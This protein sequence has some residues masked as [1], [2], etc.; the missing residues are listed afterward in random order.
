MQYV[1]FFE[2]I[3]NIALETWDESKLRELLEEMESMELG[4]HPKVN[5]DNISEREY[6]IYTHV[7]TALKTKLA[8][9]EKVYT[10]MLEKANFWF[11]ENMKDLPKVKREFTRFKKSFHPGD[12]VALK[13][14]YNKL[15]TDVEQK[16]Q[17]ETLFKS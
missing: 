2:Q 5:T 7:V 16:I 9:L 6:Q 8:N 17:L 14:R 10:M 4:M 12:N 15:V 13:T 3:L 1:D 11:M